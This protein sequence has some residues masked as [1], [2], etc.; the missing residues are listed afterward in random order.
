MEPILINYH[1]TKSN[2]HTQAM[3]AKIVW[4]LLTL[5]LIF[6]TADNI[7]AQI[8]KYSVK[9]GDEAFLSGDY[10]KAEVI[11]HSILEKEKK[12]Y[13]ALK[14]L[15][16]IK[17]KLNKLGDAES[18]V[19][20]IL[21]IPVVSG[22]NVLVYEKGTTKPKEAE[23]VDV[24]VMTLD[25]S[26]KTEDLGSAGKY[27][28]ELAGKQK[29]HYRVY[30]KETG[31][32]KLIPHSRARIEY[33]GIP[34]AT[35]KLA[36]EM[37]DQ[38]RKSMIDTS[39]LEEEEMILIHA[40]CFNMGSEKG[41]PD[42]IPI[43]EVCLTSFLMDRYE[44]TQKYF[45]SIMGFNPSQNVG[46][47]LP[48]DSL[49]WDEAND[50]CK[51]NAKRLPTEAE[52]EY[53]ARAGNNEEFYWGKQS[54]AKHANFCDSHCKLNIR[55]SEEN[56]GFSHTAPVGSFPPNPYGL[57]DMA[58][59]VGEWVYDWMAVNYY[60]QSPKENPRGPNPELEAKIS[61]SITHKVYRG[62]AWNQ[63]INEMRS[64]N[65]RGSRYQLRAEGIG[66]RCAET[67]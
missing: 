46:A 6:R 37:K 9:D 17:I 28:T 4:I 30:L 1:T 33:A 44:V 7:N 24:S 39:D 15:A 26:V 67:Q 51:K 49:T 66:F 61:Q 12:N 8:I 63:T 41:D 53:S 19:D 42:E 11:F 5:A 16:E 21:A 59:N 40:G 58:G 38:I 50:Y 60:R 54:P 10:R 32:M 43:H 13:H 55:E 45:Q 29:P 64:A 23:L 48:V 65:R 47:D 34:K 31:K 35:H 56:D 52:W 18:L 14:T 27:V 22:R 3:H 25:E 36:L 62:G 57:H 2:N 20:Q